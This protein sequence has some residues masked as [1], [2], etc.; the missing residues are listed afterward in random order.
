MMSFFVC[1]LLFHVQDHD[2]QTPKSARKLKLSGVSG[3]NVE[4]FGVDHFAKGKE[5][6]LN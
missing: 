4:V 5:R 2:R 3:M 1:E 6:V